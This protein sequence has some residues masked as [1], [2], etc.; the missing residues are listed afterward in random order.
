MPIACRLT[1]LTPYAVRQQ[2]LAAP[3]WLESDTAAAAWLEQRRAELSAML[4]PLDLMLTEEEAWTLERYCDNEQMLAG[5]P[6]PCAGDRNRAATARR[7]P[8][9]SSCRPLETPL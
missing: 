1:P 5:S 2:M 7:R 3:E 9:P 6:S 8:S 4:T